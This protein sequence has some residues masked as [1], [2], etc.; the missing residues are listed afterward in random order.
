MIDWGDDPSVEAQDYEWGDRYGKINFNSELTPRKY[1][2]KMI[3]L[4][5]SFGIKLWSDLEG[6]VYSISN[7]MKAGTPISGAKKF[8]SKYYKQHKQVALSNYEPHQP[9]QNYIYSVNTLWNSNEWIDNDESVNRYRANFIDACRSFSE[10]EFEGGFVYSSIR[11]ANPRF[12][13]LV[14]DTPWIPKKTYIEKVK[15][16]ILVFNTPAWAGC[17]GWKLGEYMALG[18]AIISTPLTNELPAPLIHGEHIHVVSGETDDIVRAIKLLINDVDY[19]KI[20]ERN[21]HA[22]YRKYASPAQSVKR[23]ADIS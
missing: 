12:Q 2:P 17:H 10:I 13:E 18:K 14:I 20:L 1:H 9:L 23:L 16:S 3:S 4:A 7:W 21:A 8:L 19:R 11:N 15:K 6:A 22:Y 5:P